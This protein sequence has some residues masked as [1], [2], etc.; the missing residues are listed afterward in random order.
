MIYQHTGGHCPGQECTTAKNTKAMASGIWK[1]L[2]GASSPWAPWSLLSGG[3]IEGLFG[4]LKCVSRIIQQSKF[5]GVIFRGFF[6]LVTHPRLDQMFFR[7]TDLW[8]P[9]LMRIY[10]SCRTLRIKSKCLL[11]PNLF[12]SWFAK[13]PPGE[14]MYLLYILGPAGL[15]NPENGILS[16]NVF[17]FYST[18]RLKICRFLIFICS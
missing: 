14:K 18:R 17:Y 13:L 2:N 4:H 5:H 9:L 11:R 8:L 3:N 10:P 6:F 1:A 16:K 12:I 7:N 15:K